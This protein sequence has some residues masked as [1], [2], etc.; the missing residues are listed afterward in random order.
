MDPGGIS[1]VVPVYNERESLPQLIDELHTV[2]EA[3]Q[4][5]EIIFV[6]D[7]STDKSLT[8]LKDRALSDNRISIIRFLKNYGK[9]A[10]LSE[11]FKKADGDYVISIDADLQDDPH[12]IPKLISILE[13]GCDLVSGWKKKRQDPFL[14]RLSSRFF[15]KTTRLLTGVKINDFNCGLKAY[16]KSLVK[17]LDLYGG[18]HRYIPVLAAKKGYQVQELVVNHRPRKYGLTKYGKERYFHGLFDLLTVLFLSRYTRRP[19]HL[20]GIFGLLSLLAGLFVNVWILVLKYGFHEPFQRHF[21]L[22]VFGVLLLILGVQFISIGLL[23]E[24]IAQTHREA[25][26]KI[27]E[28]F[29]RELEF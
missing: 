5:Y 13:K 2:L 27:I 29:E 20:F 8:Y 12:E 6:D 22:L 25:E 15:N 11:G 3:F 23:G 9:S 17:S 7:G 1:V 10:A 28:V 18:M 19:L 4:D 24:M 14:K 26:E 16:R 21:A